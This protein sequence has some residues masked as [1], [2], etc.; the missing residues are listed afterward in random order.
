MGQVPRELTPLESALHF[1]GAQ[2]RH[3][4]TARALS[5]AA[6]GRRTHDSGAL[7]GKIEKGERFPSL[8][9]TRRLDVALDTD[10]AL[11]RLWPDLEHERA[12]RDAPS[13]RPAD[14]DGFG[15][16]DLGLVWSATPQATVG[17]VAELWRTDLDRR[18]VLASAV[19]VTAAFTG[20]TREWLLNRR[21]EI[22]SDRSGRAVGQR[23]V[24]ALW[25]MCDAFG[26]AD[27][28]LGG[29]YARST[30]LHYVNQAVL[31]LLHGSYNDTIGRELMAATARLC[32]LCGFMSFD[33]GK[34]GLAQRYFI[35]ALRLAQASGNR[36]LGAHILAD[37]SIQAHYLGDAPQALDLAGAGLRTGLDCGSPSTAA[38]CAA[39]QGRAHALHVDRRACAQ[40]CTVAERALD[41]AMPADEPAWIQFFTAKALA[42]EMLTMARDLG[43]HQDVQRLAPGA[44]DSPD[45]LERRRVLWTTY[46]A[47]SYLPSEG[48]SRS[49]IDQ[50]C[51]LLGQ[52]IPALNSLSS[53]RILERVNSLR[54]ALAAHAGRASVQEVEDRFRSTI[55]A[56]GM[57]R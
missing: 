1:F 25:A 54:R 50:A 34:Q 14:G 8:A 16:G 56:V 21:D 31:P 7:I 40:A 48:N 10:G 19:W 9:L 2:L 24:D 12:T 23:D 39:L 29:G 37:M 52:V 26:A 55:V 20:P 15:V 5:Q 51:H 13:D 35:Q 6:L 38:R 41:R 30:L 42:G 44:L 57:P 28:R 11:E 53:A 33:S 47:S 22:L 46:L 18:S 17:V 49:D 32:D 3:W 43:R 27:Q 4:R 36:A 45:H